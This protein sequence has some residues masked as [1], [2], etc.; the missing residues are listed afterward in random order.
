MKIRLEWHE[1][2]MASEIGRFRQLAA[3]KKG[4][5]DKHGFAGEGW[6]E[7]V[8]GACGELAVA[9]FLG[10]YWDGGINTFKK[11]DL[12]GLQVRTRSRD[13]YDLIVRP[14]DSDLDRF[15][16]VTGRCPEYQIRGWITGS[17]AKKSDYLQ[18]YGGRP[19]AYFVPASALSSPDSMKV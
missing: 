15:V 12:P 6:S 8:E 14:G 7:H 1:I 17:N 13:S 5:D 4:L 2:L 19:A 11:P 18:V 10:I 16:L 9:R 3:M